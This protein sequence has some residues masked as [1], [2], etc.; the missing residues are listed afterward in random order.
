MYHENYMRNC[1][2][3][4]SMPQHNNKYTYDTNNNR[5]RDN[6][7]GGHRGGGRRNFRGGRGWYQSHRS[8]NKSTSKNTSYNSYREYNRDNDN[9][10]DII[11]NVLQQILDQLSY[12]AKL[13][14]NPQDIIYIYMA[15]I[16]FVMSEEYIIRPFGKSEQKQIQTIMKTQILS[17]P[18]GQFSTN[19]IKQ[20]I[21]ST[22]YENTNLL[23]NNANEPYYNDNVF[24]NIMSKNDNIIHGN[25]PQI[26]SQ[27]SG[28]QVHIIHN[29]II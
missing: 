14:Y 20:I 26:I 1:A 8:Y 13:V 29:Y 4:I 27:V 9:K 6:R 22:Q 21:D 12:P 28:H 17:K 15:V 23:N 11:N 2:Q 16:K 18:I 25:G 19:E 3:T 5:Y 10:K 7:N 24:G